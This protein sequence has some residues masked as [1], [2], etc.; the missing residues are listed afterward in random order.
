[1]RQSLI[2]LTNRE[3]PPKAIN[4]NTL[5]R[6]LVGVL[7]SGESQYEACITAINEQTYRSWELFEVRNLP[8]RDAHQKLFNTFQERASEFDLFVK[9]DAD[10]E[11]CSA[12]FFANLIE[13]TEQ[14][15][16]A[17]L[18]TIKVDDF[19]T[20]RLVWGLNVYRSSIKFGENDEIYTDKFFD[21]ERKPKIIHLKSHSTLVPAA[22]HCFNPSG[23]QSFYFGCHKAIK[24]L[25]RQSRSHMRNIRSLLWTAMRKRDHRHLI[26]YAGAATTFERNLGPECLDHGN[27]TL[28]TL[29][30]QLVEEDKQ[31][32]RKEL[33]GYFRINSKASRELKTKSAPTG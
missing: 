18:I 14:N 16:S 22:R 7:F 24:V 15:P 21:T 30:D 2:T 26:A 32:W 25:H 13:Y 9:I 10:M 28:E 29:Y 19:F 33:I 27:R 11:L 17:E 31:F 20:G 1:V 12:D 4:R 8:N 6:I 23:Y 3:Y 5:V